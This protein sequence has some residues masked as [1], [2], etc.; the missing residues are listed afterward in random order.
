VPTIPD[1][2]RVPGEVYFVH[3][4]SFGGAD[5]ALIDHQRFADDPSEVGLA[6]LDGY[7]V[8]PSLAYSDDTT[9]RFTFGTIPNALEQ[10]LR[11]SD[12]QHQVRW[13]FSTGWLDGVTSYDL[14]LAFA[15]DG[16]DPTWTWS[17]TRGNWDS[18]AF[19]NSQG[20]AGQALLDEIGH[21]DG[22]VAKL[23][24]MHFWTA[25]DTLNVQP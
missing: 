1:A 2:A 14:P 8:A 25:F 11:W 15:A 16:W 20:L 12:D 4:Q 23:A 13:D 7:T 9:L 18:R 21:T 24:G 22:T 3:Q 19:G 17:A 6:K 10:N 5:D